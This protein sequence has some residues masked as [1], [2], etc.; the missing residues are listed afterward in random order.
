[1]ITSPNVIS[2]NVTTSTFQNSNSIEMVP[3][4][5]AEWNMNLFNQP[6][7]T[8]AG[9]GSPETITLS[10]GSLSSASSNDAMQNVT[11]YT[12]AMSGNQKQIGYTV[13]TQSPY[14]Q[15]YKIVTYMKTDSDLPIMVNAYAQGGLPGEYGSTTVD[16]N[17]FG[18]TKIVT[19]LGSSATLGAI[20]YFTYT[21]NLSSYGADNLT[22]VN[23]FL[24]QPEVYAT[25]FFDYQNNSLWPTDSVFNYFRPGESYVTSGNSYCALKS[26]RIINT[27]L[28]NNPIN[29]SSVTRTN[30]ITNPSFEDGT[31]NGYSS[32]NSLTTSTNYSYVGVYSSL[33]TAVSSNDTNMIYQATTIPTSGTYTASAYF[34]VPAGSNLAGQQVVL[35]PESGQTSIV[36]HPTTLIAGQWVRTYTTFNSDAGSVPVVA[37][38]NVNILQHNGDQLYSDAWLLESG[39]T[40]G[41]YFE[42]TSTSPLAGSY[43]PPATSIIQNPQF[44]MVNPPVPMYKNVA[45]SDM[46]PYKYFVSDTSANIGYPSISAVYHTGCSANKIVLKFNTIVTNPNIS[47]SLDNNTIWAGSV[48]DSTE[49][50]V[51]T[52]YYDGSSWSTNSWT[53]MPSFI[54]TK[55]STTGNI[56]IYQTFNQITV[57]QTDAAINSTFSSYSNS[58]LSDDATRMH[59]IEIS[60]RIEIDISKYVM[61]LDINKQ[62]D[63]KNN[64]IPISSINPNDAELTLSS[65]PI[66]GVNNAP[67]PIFS[68]QNNLSSNILYNMMRKNIKFY[69][70]WKLI[71]Y[72]SITGTT[73]VNY[74]D[75]NP[76]NQTYI[77]AGV[78]WSNSWD[79]TDIQTVKVACYDV[80][81]YLQM[82]PVPDYVAS[83]KPIFEIITDIMDLA[84]YTDYDVDSLFKVCNDTS[85]PMDMYYYFCNSQ[86]GTVYDA[87]SEL[88]LAHQIGAYIDEFGVMR[89]LSLADI[90]RNQTS[91]ATFDDSSI[92]QGGYSI[93]NKAKPGMITVSYQEPKVLQS[94]ALQNATSV[95]IENSPSFIYTTSN[96]VV[97]SQKNADSVGYNYLST[98]MLQNDN[99][100]TMN[101]NDLLDI[102]HTYLL[103][104][105]GYAVIE[106]EIVS[107]LYKEYTLTQTSNPSN[108]VTVYPKT[109]IE[110]AAYIDSFVKQNNVGFLNNSATLTG[111]SITTSTKTVNIANNDGGSSTTETINYVSGITYTASS[112]FTAGQFQVGQRVSVVGFVPDQYNISGVITAS[113]STTFTLAANIN[114]GTSSF[115]SVSDATN[116]FAIFTSDN[117]FD[118]TITPTGKIANVQR[119]MFGTVANDHLIISGSTV[120]G[121]N[122]NLAELSLDL[123]SYNL[124]TTTTTTIANDH[125]ASPDNPTIEFINVQPSSNSQTLILNVGIVGLNYCTYSARFSLNA[126][127]VCSG[128]VFFGLDPATSTS[129][130]MY[131]VELIKLHDYTLSGTTVTFSSKN[132]YN[133]YLVFY[134]IVSGTPNII[135]WT[136]V[137]GTVG[138]IQ[139]N[140]EKVLYKSSGKGTSNYQYSYATDQN[141]NLRVAIS[142][143][144]GTD[145]ETA[146]QLLNV[147]LNNIEITGWQIPI[148]AS[149][150]DTDNTSIMYWTSGGSTY[151][152][153]S[154]PINKMTGLRQKV[155]FS[156]D[157][158][159]LLYS[160]YSGYSSSL[161]P[162]F[163][164]GMFPSGTQVAGAAG[165]ASYVR[166]VHCCEK[167][168][169]ERSVN[170]Y[171]QDRE[172][173]NGMVQNRNVYNQYQS[174]I[175][176]TN[177]DVVGINYYDVQYQTPAATSVDV[178]PIEYL[179]YY[180][181]G[182]Q[183]IDQQFYQQQVVDEY[184]L[185]YS[186]PINTGFRAR[187][188][189]VN[190]CGHMVYLNKQSDSL[191]A[192]TVVLNLWTHEVIAP[193]DPEVIQKIL[194]PA[195]ISEVIQVDS[196]WIQSKASANKLIDVIKIGNDGFSKDTA[197]QIFGNPM[198]QV[199]DVITINYS[200]AGITGEKYLVHEVAHVFNKGLKTTL[201]LNSLRPGIGY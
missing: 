163:P 44:L 3:I 62:L 171:Y 21:I 18:Y 160:T 36:E 9:T 86:S 176:Q 33:S 42:G 13:N 54:E 25:T 48:N 191:N 105:D 55:G 34:Y 194:D 78:Y 16:I 82:V 40:L 68:S 128:G 158:T 4:V 43:Y 6:Y 174:C 2:G 45:A 180:F 131:F 190:N 51:L 125:L 111:A 117:S 107:F 29:N 130:G 165:T 189:I 69:F 65:I 90:M 8:V 101:K 88:F 12:F 181:P 24:T 87:L 70:S 196:P 10:N 150:V 138:Y 164:Y 198:V 59:L 123:S 96:D 161:S 169:I 152:W 23:V 17:A 157:P 27:S 100:F 32:A 186:T 170:Y 75:N 73:F 81:N 119:G 98:S 20:S 115:P 199:G 147:F 77:P 85:K 120:N 153:S 92:I 64:Y 35:S 113:D 193:S 46:A 184:S 142:T 139:S 72:S 30:L 1:M 195:N 110:L 124:S 175:V 49:S 179:W 67:I 118:V 15:A 31:T 89:F 53:T 162:V 140:F 5:S 38:I 122:K 178:L 106:G 126:N 97:W 155:P 201:T 183:P 129:E 143:S 56:S 60:P 76:T 116:A 200:L 26:N 91:V 167:P 156:L 99:F 159:N 145:G 151:T 39:S 188:A 57:T 52:L 19:Y 135:S 146:G 71:S 192:F 187:M 83:N 103:N 154:T 149:S 22:G 102:F 74:S 185:S 114:L 47:V 166:E 168:L 137:T 144:N 172:F 177:P 133:Y 173:L 94:L 93:T 134:Q 66:A 95:G 7:I 182:T 148:V 112:A 50:G 121:S 136:D 63:S 80:V 108:T 28:T 104:N 41:S 132:N 109:D 11:T 58:Y 37:R 79:E 14:S 61:E 127:D 141:Y 84:G 197:V